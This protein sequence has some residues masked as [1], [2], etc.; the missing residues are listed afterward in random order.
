MKLA[1]ALYLDKEK[2]YSAFSSPSLSILVDAA[3]SHPLVFL[4][5]KIKNKNK[6]R[7][8]KQKNKEN[9]RR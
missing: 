5:I 9:A 3:H 1:I 4:K 7:N 2:Y 6:N 8:R